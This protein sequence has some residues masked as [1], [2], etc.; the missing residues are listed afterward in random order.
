MNPVRIRPA[1]RH[2]AVTI[3][4]FTNGLVSD[5]RPGG[6]AGVTLEEI[7]RNGFGADPLFEALIAEVSGRPV[8]LASFYRGYAGWQGKAIAVVHAIYVDPAARRL[9]VARQ[10]MARMALITLQRGWARVEL[11]VEEQRPAIQFY[12]DIG[13]IDMR[14]RHM[15][16]GGTELR[17]LALEAQADG[18]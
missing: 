10:L 2:D 12:E 5:H 8:G 3:F 7:E 1:E 9:G 17:N 14:H 4:R 15:R 11:F 13:M 6:Q 16:L 18:R